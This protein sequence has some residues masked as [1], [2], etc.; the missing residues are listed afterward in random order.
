MLYFFHGREVAVISHGLVKERVVPPRE[1]ARAVERK[2]VFETDP[3][4]HTF[5]PETEP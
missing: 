5:S 2:R 3:Q 1:I 4:H